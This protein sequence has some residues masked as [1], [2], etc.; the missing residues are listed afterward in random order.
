MGTRF[1]IYWQAGLRS[2]NR[3]CARWR[4][5]R[6]G[7]HRPNDCISAPP[8]ERRSA[9]ATEARKE[10]GR[11]SKSRSTSVVAARLDPLRMLTIVRRIASRRLALPILEND[12]DGADHH[13]DTYEV[14][15][16]FTVTNI[17]D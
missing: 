6:R 13:G 1:A 10:R 16:P 5:P 14:V 7:H 17:E 15:P 2:R 3:T 8:E 4:A 9:T 11:A 12:R